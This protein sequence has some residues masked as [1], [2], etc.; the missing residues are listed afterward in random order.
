ME[1]VTRNIEASIVG[2]SNKLSRND[3]P[4]LEVSVLQT[5]GW[6]RRHPDAYQCWDPETFQG[7]VTR[8]GVSGSLTLE[9]QNL[10]GTDKDPDDER[11]YWWGLIGAIFDNGDE[12]PTEFGTYVPYGE[13]SDST[14]YDQLPDGMR[15]QPRPQ[16]QA[17]PPKGAPPQQTSSGSQSGA[18]ADPTRLSIESQTALKAAVEATSSFFQLLQQ[19][20]P[21]L[22]PIPLMRLFAVALRQNYYM[23]IGLLATDR[24]TC[25]V[26]DKL[27]SAEPSVPIPN[28]DISGTAPNGYEEANGEGVNY[29]NS[30]E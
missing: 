15:Q 22:E 21:D 26:L 12:M 14:P 28:P 9:R 16:S 13:K 25:L 18:P 10:K 1:L 7:L 11:S 8:I 20:T 5:S 24:D 23:C 30:G 4:F 19:T 6:I 17:P 27:W 2:V 3:K 29:A